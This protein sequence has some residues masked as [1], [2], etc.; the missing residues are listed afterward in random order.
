MDIWLCISIPGGSYSYL[1]ALNST[2]ETGERIKEGAV[3]EERSPV[4][5]ANLDFKS[6]GS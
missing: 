2:K 1:Q 6:K 5:V 4:K 3:I